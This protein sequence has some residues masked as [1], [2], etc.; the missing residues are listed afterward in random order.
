MLNKQMVT[1]MGL[2][3]LL[4]IGAA[5]PS[6]FAQTVLQVPH[7][8][9]FENLAV[10]HTPTNPTT[11]VLAAA[12]DEISVATA[13]LFPTYAQEFHAQEAALHEQFVH[14][15]TSEAGSYASAQAQHP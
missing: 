15:L 2:V 10:S 6:A 3:G 12:A 14:S 11:G 7:Q 9:T 5:I 4:A 1:I 13:G 8:N